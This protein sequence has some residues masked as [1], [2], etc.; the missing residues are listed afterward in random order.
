MNQTRYVSPELKAKVERAIEEADSVP[1]FVARKRAAEE[2]ETRGEQMQY[3][4]LLTTDLESPYS[5]SLRKRIREKLAKEGYDLIVFDISGQDRIRLLQEI[6]SGAGNLKGV[7]VSVS[8]PSEEMIRYISSYSVPMVVIGNQIPG[9]SC[10][11]VCSANYEGAYNATSHLIR[12]GH[13]KIAILCGAD[14]VESNRDRIQGY[15]RALKANNIEYL[16]SLVVDNL[17]GKKRIHDILSRMLTGAHVPTAMFLANYEIVLN[18]YRFLSENSI[19]CPRDVSIVGFNDFQ[20]ASYVEPA[21]TTIRQDVDSMSENA[22]RLLLSRIRGQNSSKH[23]QLIEIPT[24]LCIRS[25]TKSMGKGPFG[26]DAG[27]IS[28]VSISEEEKKNS[29][30]GKYTAAISFHYSGKSWMHLQEMGIREIFDKLDISI[31]SITDAHFDPQLQVKQLK[32][33]QILEPDILI[34]IPADTKVTADA[35][36]GFVGTKTRLIFISNVPEGILP[37]DYVTCVSVNE[38]SHGRN[39]GRG[40]GEYMR[41]H[42][43]TRIAVIKHK[44]EGFYAT[45]QRDQAGMQIIEEEY[46]ELEI[47]AVEEFDREEDAYEIT[48]RLMKEHPEIQGMYVSWEGPTEYVQNALRDVGRPDVAISTGDLEYNMAMSI[49]AGGA[50]K[51]VSAQCP[52]D[53]GQAIALSAAKALLG[54]HIPSYIS[55]E[56]VFTDKYNLAKS[57]KKVHKEELPADIREALNRSFIKENN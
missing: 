23:E 37:E 33:I 44:S 2:V 9:I 29:R 54:E 34:S 13:E 5:L 39:I 22:V 50:V 41:K 42:G 36:R 48:C 55:V 32:S 45:R 8:N 24:E 28:D 56:P 7:L 27:D 6:H 19:Q 35:Y 40:I 3:V 49:A 11:R 51:A 10:D 53:Q 17:G 46:P 20:W 12:S 47:C 26:E 52:Y 18:T 4:I 30:K 38:L 57:W 43:L 16:D 14:E 1:N 25:S 15:M 21:L 31:I